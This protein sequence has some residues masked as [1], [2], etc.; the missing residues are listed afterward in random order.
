MRRTWTTGWRLAALLSAAVPAAAWAGEAAAPAHEGLPQSAPV[1]FHLGPLPVNN[2]MVVSWVVAL[3]LIVV[4]RLATRRMTLVPGGLQNLVELV[5]GGLYDFLEGI[6]GKVM[7]RR[8]FWF[9][10]TV[11][12]FILC[13]NWFALLP[14]V[15]TVGWGVAEHGRFVVETPLI[16]GVNADLNMT[17][18]MALLFFALWLVWAIQVNGPVGFIKH[19]FAAPKDDSGWLMKIMMIVVFLGAGVLE[20]VSILFRPI[21]LSLRLYGNIYAGET[22]LET[23]M[24]LVPWL[25]WLLPVPFYFMEVLVGFV[26]ALVFMLLAAVFTF[27]ICEHADDQ[28][29]HA[30]PVG[31][32]ASG[33]G[34]AG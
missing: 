24:H 21:A 23:M 3:L 11:F 8:G 27:L 15:G 14:G 29:A 26:Q 10:A 12:I 34:V 28:E 33:D 19:I 31:Q 30:G 17:M 20:V 2:S 18:A 25:S 22:M 7:T 4:A 32:P 9:F 5:V 6:I 13:T 1:L 16:R